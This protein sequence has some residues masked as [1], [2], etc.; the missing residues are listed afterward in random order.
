MQ[1]IRDRHVGLVLRQIVLLSRMKRWRIK[2]F[3]LT[4][5]EV[6]VDASIARSPSQILVLSVRDVEMGLGVAIFLRKTE[7]DHVDLISTLAN[8][9]EEVIGLDIAVDEVAR[10]NIFDA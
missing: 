8:S 3:R 10:M 1:E 6:G 5:A 9:H 2:Y 4:D 7:I